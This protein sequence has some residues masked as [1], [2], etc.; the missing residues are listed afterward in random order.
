MSKRT[1]SEILDAVMADPLVQG[2]LRICLEEES[3]PRTVCPECQFEST[4]NHPSHTPGCTRDPHYKWWH[5][6]GDHMFGKMFSKRTAAAGAA[7]KKMEN[8]DLVEAAIAGMVLMAFADGSCSDEEIANLTAIVEASDS[9]S[10]HQSE[11]PGMVDKYVRLMKAGAAIG[12]TKLMKEISDVKGSEDEKTEVFACI[13]SIAQ[14]DGA[15][16][17]EEMDL[18]KRIGRQLGLNPDAF[19]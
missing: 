6:Q 14:G 9:F 18:L 8:K 11:I 1:F 2:Y 10:A 3:A 7:I 4:P 5:I 12:R 19:L 13:V 17:A 16:G 15:V